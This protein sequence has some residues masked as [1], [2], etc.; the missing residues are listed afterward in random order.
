[1]PDKPP[2]SNNGLLELLKKLWLPVA[3]FIGAVTLVYNFYQLWL[4]DQTTVTYVTA[5]AGLI[6]LV[7]VLWWV[8]FSNRK[9]T[10][11]AV[12]PIGANVTDVSPR[13]GLRYQRYARIFLVVIFIGIISGGWLLSTHRQELKDKLVVLIAAFEGPEDVYGL[14]NEIIENL[15]SDFSDDEGIEIVVIDDVIALTQG[16]DYAR[17][18]GKRYMADIVIWAWYRPTENPNITIHIENPTQENILSLE[19][20]HIFRPA[21]TLAELESFTFQQYAGYEISALISFLTGLIDYSNKDYETAIE[22]FDK[23]LEN[24]SVPSPYIYYYR[25]NANYWVKNIQRAIQDY[26]KSIQINP[27]FA[28]AYFN[29]GA[30]YSDLGDYQS[31]IQDFD[32]VIQINPQD[33]EA[34][35]NRG[36]TYANLGDYQRAIQDVDKAIQINPQFAEAYLTRGVSYA[37]LGDYQHAIQDFDKVIQINPQFAEAYYNR[38]IVYQRLGKTAEAEADFKKYEELTGQKP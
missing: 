22:C 37:Y 35:Y 30:T 7:F 15:N 19:E 1:M 11:D 24:M 25:G 9:T 5:G 2:D 38:G 27:Q 32:K 26:D 28:E 16:S 4:G 6:V 29:R 14:R 34:Y 23:A 20:G 31:A 3:G 21:T 10:R 12:W 13:Y 33:A 8:G 18:L 36:T 17:K